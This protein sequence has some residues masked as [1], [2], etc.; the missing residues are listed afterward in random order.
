MYYYAG[1]DELRVDTLCLVQKKC[2]V[3]LGMQMIIG[4]LQSCLLGGYL[5]FKDETVFPFDSRV[6]LRLQLS[7]HSIT[8]LA[9]R[10]GQVVS[11]KSTLDHVNKGQVLW[12][13][14]TI[15]HAMGVG[16]QNWVKFGPRSCWMTPQHRLG[17]L[18]QGRT[19]FVLYVLHSQWNLMDSRRLL[20]VCE[21][22]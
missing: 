18:F 2:R 17:R 12:K 22:I 13:M 19:T 3:L 10:G 9:K 11:R 15:V 1:T 5:F 21:V 4:K 14:S 6:H 20:K 8:T 16:G 7:G